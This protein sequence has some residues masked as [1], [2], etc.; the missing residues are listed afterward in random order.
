MKYF[1]EKSD[2]DYANYSTIWKDNEHRM[3][4]L[5]TNLS[6]SKQMSG[7]DN[8]NDEKDIL[9][10]RFPS[11]QELH[12]SVYLKRIIGGNGIILANDRSWFPKEVWIYILPA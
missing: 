5:Q 6:L 8:S 11:E 7:T 12:N 4:F 3:V 2:V 1:I 9:A 10:I